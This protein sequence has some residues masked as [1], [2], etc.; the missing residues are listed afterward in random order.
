LVMDFEIFNCL[1]YNDFFYIF[2][3]ALVPVGA[4]QCIILMTL[5]V[6]Y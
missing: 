1:I 5:A 4:A 2:Y 3:R 6:S